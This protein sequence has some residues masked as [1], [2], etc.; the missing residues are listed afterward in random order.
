MRNDHQNCWSF[1]GHSELSVALK[2]NLTNGHLTDDY[3]TSLRENG[4]QG[5]KDESRNL[6]FL[7]NVPMYVGA[8]GIKLS[9]NA[10]KS[11]VCCHSNDAK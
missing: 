4:L 7:T 5:R 11:H 2:I 10:Q 3:E 8:L 9:G 6:L 1:S